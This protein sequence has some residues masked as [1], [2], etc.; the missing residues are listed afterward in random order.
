MGNVFI[1]SFYAYPVNFNSRY[2]LLNDFSFLFVFNNDPAYSG[3]IFLN[4]FLVSY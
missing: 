4:C 2:E 3:L 1:M